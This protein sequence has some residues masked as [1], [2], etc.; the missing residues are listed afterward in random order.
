MGAAPGDPYPYLQ[1]P[2]AGIPMGYHVIGRMGTRVTRVVMTM[3]M[4]M[5]MTLLC[6]CTGMRVRVRARAR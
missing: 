1:L 2:A 6:E 3:T 4:M 5:M